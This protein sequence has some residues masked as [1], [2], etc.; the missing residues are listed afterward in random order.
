MELQTFQCK[1]LLKF[2]RHIEQSRDVVVP[3][4]RVGIS[5]EED[6]PNFVVP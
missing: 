2:D 4:S 5:N 1:L 6:V 3:I